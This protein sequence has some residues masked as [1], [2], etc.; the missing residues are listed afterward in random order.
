MDDLM[1]S[2]VVRSGLEARPIL[3]THY[4]SFLYVHLTPVLV[5]QSK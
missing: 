1:N 2:E 3:P 5:E 4:C